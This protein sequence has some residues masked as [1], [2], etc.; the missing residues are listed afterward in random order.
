M[1]LSGAP[2]SKKKS[3]PVFTFPDFNRRDFLLREM[4]DARVALVTILYAL[5]VVAITFG[6]SQFSVKLAILLG[7]A[8]PAGLI[9]V[10]PLVADTSEF[11]RKNWM[12]P[13]ATA[14][15]TWL[16]LWILLS[17]PPFQDFAPP[18]AY[19]LELYTYNADGDNWTVDNNWTSN[20][21]VVNTTDL[22]VVVQVL[23]NWEVEEV[24][25]NV[26]RGQQSV[27]VATLVEL[28]APNDY[29]VEYDGEGED[30]NRYYL[31]LDDGLQPGEYTFR[32]TMTDAR[33]NESTKNWSVAVA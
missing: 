20:S 9:R 31:L 1:V 32:F 30:E 13:I 22:L 27:K 12:G 3:E 17:N 10:L 5:G 4:R 24:R 18:R 28:P 29:G 33:D 26:L 8:A 25:L 15:F 23:D 2:V 6:V 14:L 11:E 21:T 19:D 16:G 7:L